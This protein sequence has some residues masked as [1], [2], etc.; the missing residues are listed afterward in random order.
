MGIYTVLDANEIDNAIEADLDV[1]VKKLSD[2]PSVREIILGGGFG[3]GEG[4]VILKG[5][6][7]KPVNDYDIFLIVDDEKCADFKKLE[8][9]LAQTIGIRLIDLIPVQY[10]SLSTLPANQF[11]YDLKYGGRP[12]WG[13]K[14]LNIIPAF[15][16][17]HLDGGAGK[18]LLLNRLICIIEA[19]SENFKTRNMS[20]DEKFFLVNQ[21]GKAVSACVEALLM[22]KNIY[23]H[24]L[25][26]RKEI[27]ESAF[28]GKKELISLNSTAAYFKLQPSMNP[29]ID[30]VSYWERT[31]AQF[32]DVIADFIA[33]SLLKSSNSFGRVLKKL[34]NDGKKTAPTNIPVERVELLLLLYRVAPVSARDEILS[35]ALAEF[36][37]ISKDKT[38]ISGWENLREATAR[39]WHQIHQ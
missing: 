36:E 23:H 33:P 1:I 18:T 30:A 32:T 15:K 17:G 8:K 4:S 29:D 27:F 2:I 7:A 10:S 20:D 5:G 25:R 9:E 3:R 12:I 35:F 22:K 28:A 26:R 38:K 6:I 16:E 14:H 34:K 19:Y 39:L 13:E 21:T 24:S 31:V 37:D 11:Y